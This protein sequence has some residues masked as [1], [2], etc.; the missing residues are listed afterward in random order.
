VLFPV[1]DTRKPFRRNLAMPNNTDSGRDDRAEPILGNDT[2]VAGSGGTA[3]KDDDQV[4][5]ARGQMRVRGGMW[6]GDVTPAPAETVAGGSG[7]ERLDDVQ[8][9]DVGQMR[10]AGGMQGVVVTPTDRA[11]AGD[12]HPAGT[13]DDTIS[14]S[15][16]DFGIGQDRV[17]GGQG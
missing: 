2:I 4:D 15:G 12:E 6:Q 11:Q 10:I 14:G 8:V 7:G 1:E 16:R 3:R 9:D 13:G 17:K 5:H